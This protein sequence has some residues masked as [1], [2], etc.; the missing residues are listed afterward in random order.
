MRRIEEH[1]SQ[2]PYFGISVTVERNPD[3]TMENNIIKLTKP[4]DLKRLVLRGPAAFVEGKFAVSRTGV[5]PNNETVKIRTRARIDYS[6]TTLEHL[7]TKAFNSDRIAR[8]DKLRN[9]KAD[10]TGNATFLSELKATDIKPVVESKAIEGKYDRIVYDAT[11]KLYVFHT[12]AANSKI[13]APRTKEELQ[14]DLASDLESME[15]DARKAFLEDQL[16]ALSR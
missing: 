5:G 11:S 9:L 15:P 3:T 7:L 2:Q 10:D 1:L 13:E 6:N 12:K 8:Q 14:A 4:S 16:A